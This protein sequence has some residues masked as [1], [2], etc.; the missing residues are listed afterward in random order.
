MGTGT[1]RLGTGTYSLGIGAY[2]LGVG[3][4]PLFGYL[5]FLNP[6]SWSSP[7]SA[8]WEASGMKSVLGLCKAWED[9]LTD[10]HKWIDAY[11]GV[12]AEWQEV[13]KFIIDN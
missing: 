4:Y 10:V 3:T 11:E 2:V 8:E 13:K 9:F 6:K 12:E 7:S 5:T 1:C